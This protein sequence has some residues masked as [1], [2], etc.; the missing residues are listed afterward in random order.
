MSA[1]LLAALRRIRDRSIAQEAAM[2]EANIWTEE[3]THLQQET[4]EL[5]DA[6]IAEAAAPCAHPEESRVNGEKQCARCG[7]VL[8]AATAV[9]NEAT[10]VSE[11]SARSRLD[12]AI[13]DLAEAVE[14]ARRKS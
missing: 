8:D 9:V 12:C 11:L 3:D 5:V 4:M 7:E 1:Q 10:A 6:A 2:Q 13:A 14:A